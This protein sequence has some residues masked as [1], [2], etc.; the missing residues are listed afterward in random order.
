MNFGWQLQIRAIEENVNPKKIFYKKGEPFSP[1]SEISFEDLNN[2]EILQEVEL[3][4]YYRFFSIFNQLLDAN[5][6]E[7]QEL[8]KVL[9][10]NLYHH[11]LDIDMF[12]GMNRRE[13]YI[14]F[15][16][17]N[18]EEGYLGKVLKENFS[19]FSKKEKR[20]IANGILSLYETAECIFILKKVTKEVFIKSYIFSN[21]D[22]KDE[23][24]FYLRVKETEVNRKKIEFIKY[25]FLPYKYN[26][27][28]FWE[29]I[30]GVIGEDEF[31]KNDEIVIY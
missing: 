11:L 17:K 12:Q 29:Y 1:Y 26:V 4:P 20:Y 27:E 15:M 5:L 3:N 2:K 6:D 13:F 9:F 30:F 28:I 10:D 23:V 19:I 18:I 24:V 14:T 31:M 22:N 21:T 25:L 8:I 16:I 7:N